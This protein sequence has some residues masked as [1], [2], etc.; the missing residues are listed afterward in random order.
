MNDIDQ[1]ALDTME[2]IYAVDPAK[3]P[4]GDTQAKAQ[5]QCMIYAAIKEAVEA[6]R[7]RQP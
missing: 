3:L 5:I 7:T 1:I 6:E 4:G 2:K